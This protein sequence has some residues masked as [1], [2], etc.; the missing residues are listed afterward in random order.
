MK[1]SPAKSF[2]CAVIAVWAS[3][4][5]SAQQ[6]VNVGSAPNDGTGDPARTAFQ[7]LNAN[8]VE[9]YADI[10]ALFAQ[11]SANPFSFGTSVTPTFGNSVSGTTAT[12]TAG[13]ATFTCASNCSN[14]AVGKFVSGSDGANNIWPALGGLKNAVILTIVGST[15]TTNIVT[16]ASTTPGTYAITV[17]SDRW[18]TTSVGLTNTLGAY[19]YF[20]GGAAKGNST[21]AQGYISGY[22]DTRA[23]NCWLSDLGSQNAVSFTGGRSSDGISIMDIKLG[24]QDNTAIAHNWWTNYWQTELLAGVNFGREVHALESTVFNFN[25]NSQKLDPYLFNLGNTIENLRLTSGQAGLGTMYHASD[26]I[27]II[28]IN[29]TGFETGILFAT[30]ALDEVTMAHPPALALPAGA[31]GYAISWYEATGYT[32]P[33]WN[34]YATNTTSVAN[35]FA[36]NDNNATVSIANAAGTGQVFIGSGA[37]ATSGTHTATFSGTGLAAGLDVGTA[38]INDPATTGTLSYMA[39]SHFGIPTLTA[40]GALTITTADTVA[41]E[42]C[43]VGGTN[44]TV[45]NC[46]ALRVL[47]G[48]SA[49]AG[50]IILNARVYASSTAPTIASGFNTASYSISAT[51]TAAFQ[52]TVGTSTGTSTGVLT[53]PA[54]TTGWAC[55]VA[56]IT[57]P[58]SSMVQQTGSTTTSVTV[59]NYVRTTGVAGNFTN[60]DKLN[61]VCGAF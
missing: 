57:T 6:P 31:T 25:A 53:M 19:T 51:T 5:F 28:P 2:L 40:A 9:E 48:T 59:T 46:T 14:L 39:V 49:F 54:A 41:I 44:V 38:T 56:D 21:W 16:N 35:T 10:A 1:L 4:V 24:V 52:V 33:A 27:S 12:V 7:K 30:G 43:P 23:W 32:T 3:A 45:T 13:S 34:L 22:C 47:A 50:P 17:G 8:D 55:S 61:F 15:V 20:G 58:A 18:N 29:S 11:F 37:L 42:G 36:L 60:S 26:A